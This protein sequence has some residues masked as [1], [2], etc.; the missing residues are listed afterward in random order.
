[1]SIEMMILVIFAVA[2][3]LLPLIKLVGNVLLLGLTIMED[4]QLSIDP[5]PVGS[6]GIVMMAPS[7]LGYGISRDSSSAA[8]CVDS[9]RQQK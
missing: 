4:N 2:L 1:M 6:T 5:L 7:A 8:V 9:V 3:L